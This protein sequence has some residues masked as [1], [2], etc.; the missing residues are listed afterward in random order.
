MIRIASLSLIL[1]V[2]PLLIAAPRVYLTGSSV[3]AI[4][5]TEAGVLLMGGGGDV[6]AAMRWFLQKANGGDVV[7]LRASGSDGYNTYL[8]SGLGVS[9]NSVRSIVYASREDAEDPESLGLIRSAEA[10]FIAGGDQSKYIRF[11]KG[12]PVQELLNA[13]VSAGKPIGGTSAGMAVLAE[14]SYSAMHDADLTSE[15]AEADPETELITLERG[16]L[17]IPE[18]AGILTDTHFTERDRIGRLDIMLDRVQTLYKVPAC[19]LAADERTA[20]CI[21]GNGAAFVAG[22]GAVTLLE[23]ETAGQ[24]VRR[25]QDGDTLT[26]PLRP[27]ALQD[28]QTRGRLVIVGGGLRSSNAAVYEAFIKGM[29]K[30]KSGRIG[31]IPAA[32][33][34]PASS[35]AAM[36]KDLIRHG[37]DP[38]AITALPLAVRDDPS[39]PDVDESGWSGNGSSEDLAAKIRQLQAVWFT[40]GDQSRITEVLLNPD[41]TQTPALEAIRAVYANGGTIGGT[42]AGAAIQSDVMILGGTSPEALRS[43]R[44][45]TYSSMKDQERGPLVLGKGLGF[46]PHGTID[47]HFDRKCRLGRLIVALL[48]SRP[49]IVHGYGIDE[50]TALVYDAHANE[51][52]VRGPGSVVMIDV[53]KAIRGQDHSINGIRLSVLGD[54]DRLQWPGPVVTVN[55]VKSATGGSEYMEIKD[56]RAGGV[57]QPYSGRLEDILGYLLV[58]NRSGAEVVSEI[59]YNDGATFRTTFRKDDNTTGFWATLDGQKDS[60]T[61]LDA[62]LDI[63]PLVDPEESSR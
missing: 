40:G 58:D 60:Y 4:R 12:T 39:T 46:F 63:G 28:P 43:G 22:E 6:D 1:L 38:D 54:G 56:P 42:S 8:Y 17:N 34:K 31:I 53:S 27:P 23:K 57:M 19:G 55:P 24:T 45:G 3:D 62:V 20:L 51:A 16:F 30:G 9:V 50:D 32:S 10:I 15:R 25:F 37:A 2:G 18:L 59:H 49:R 14:F 13:H 26:F 11:W 5:V 36:R 21:E 41:G 44:A 35:A 48:E 52:T 7:V 33:T 61:T 47:Q 29:P